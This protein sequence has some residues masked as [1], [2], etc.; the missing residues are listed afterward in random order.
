M[1]VNVPP[2]VRFALY[3][4]G[5][6]ATPLIAY[7]FEGGS[8]GTAEVTLAGAYLALINLLAASKTDLSSVAVGPHVTSDDRGTVVV[9]APG[10]NTTVDTYAPG[11]EPVEIKRILGKA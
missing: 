6:L 11:E 5:A 1:P 8:I 4:L 10:P 7:L 2:K 9:T 3:I